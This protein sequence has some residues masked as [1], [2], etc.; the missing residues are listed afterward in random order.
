MQPYI[1]VAKDIGYT[2]QIL[3]ELLRRGRGDLAGRLARKAFLLAESVLDFDG[4]AALWNLF[5]I[6][7]QLL[8]VGQ[9]QLFQILLS[10]LARLVSRRDPANTPL[11]QLLH[12]LLFQLKRCVGGGDPTALLARVLEQAWMMNADM[13]FGKLDNRFI[14]TYC[15]LNLDACSLR[16]STAAI[17]A[18]GS[19]IK[20]S[21]PECPTTTT[22]DGDNSC[23]QT[24]SETIEWLCQFLQDPSNA[25]TQVKT[26]NLVRLRTL[27]TLQKA[28]KDSHLHTNTS[29]M[30]QVTTGLIKTVLLQDLVRFCANT[31]AEA[32]ICQ[33]ATRAHLGCVASTMR[34]LLDGKH[35][36]SKGSEKGQLEEVIEQNRRLL[37]CASMRMGRWIRR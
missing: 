17:D 22:S 20:Q 8:S 19:W 10:H 28:D 35:N 24:F 2:F 37:R 31:S 16:P 33:G 13:L 14:S 18:S 15:Y 6:L 4:P 34:A 9:M 5:S 12:A 32:D 11:R 30:L 26:F 25:M 36:K 23:E 29:I 7:H 1:N 27:A 3:G 21:V